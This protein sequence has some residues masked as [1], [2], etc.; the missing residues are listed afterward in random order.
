M[1]FEIVGTATYVPVKREKHTISAD[2]NNKFWENDKNKFGMKM[3]MKMGWSEGKGLGKNEDGRA[4]YIKPTV[5]TTKSGR[6]LLFQSLQY[7]ICIFLSLLQAL[8][9]ILIPPRIGWQVVAN[10]TTY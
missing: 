7:L 5:N 10:S 2:P 8:V 4:D 9:Q 3:M 6:H 1:A